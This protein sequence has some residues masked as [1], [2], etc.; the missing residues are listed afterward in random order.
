MLAATLWKFQVTA[1]L[2]NPLASLTS[3]KLPCIAH[4]QHSPDQT[5]GLSDGLHRM[6]YSLSKQQIIDCR[7]RSASHWLAGAIGHHRRHCLETCFIIQVIYIFNIQLRYVKAFK[8]GS[9]L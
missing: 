8:L 1:E 5:T 6:R 2:L 9:S 7:L 3:W 4:D